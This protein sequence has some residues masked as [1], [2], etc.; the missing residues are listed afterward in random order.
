MRTL[1]SAKNL[2][3]SLGITFIVIFLGFV[4]R[5]V[6]VDNIG[7]QYLGLNG[8][9]TNILGMMALLEGGF[10]TSV[11]YNMYKPLAEDDRPRIIALL[12][13]YRKVYRYIAL[14]LFLFSLALYPFLG[15]FLKDGDGLEYV[16][17]VYFIFVFNS[18]V[19]YFTAYKWSIINASQQVYK[20]TGYNLAYQIAQNLTKLA[21]LYYTKNYI[22]YLLV[23]SALLLLLN[24][25]IVH[26]ANQLFPYIRTKQKHI[27]DKDTKREIV[28][29]MKNLF[30]NKVG[31]YFMFS[32]D[33][34]IISSFVSVATVGLY[35]NYTLL[36]S[37]VKSLVS[38]SLDSFSESV[39]NLIASENSDKVYEIFK[40][41]FFFNFLASS[42]A[43]I[44]LY[45]TLTPFIDW[46][47]GSQYLLT[48]A[49][50]VVILL[51]FYVDTMRTSALTFKIKA[52][53]FKQDRWTPFLQ[54]V[55]NLVLSL[56]FV[57]YW[58][59]TGVLFATLIAILSIGFWQFPR[60]CYK[61][62]FH[63]SLWLY[64]QRYAVYTL[65]ACAALA[66]SLGIIHFCKVENLF[67]QCVINGSISLA[68]SSVIYVAA[69]HCTAEY[70]VLLE[71]VRAILP[72]KRHN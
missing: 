70:R 54:G 3:S 55:I 30:I 32:T 40:S 38:K 42:L 58:G 22:L 66:A 24:V 60:L 19:G 28:N 26:K 33:N 4:T 71:H 53:L 43:V 46:W 5:K 14:G 36:T 48:H 29:N 6:F 51:N 25:G 72:K 49:T 15:Y 8:L 35:S 45:C 41:A 23:E 52:G 2:A 64:F 31:G 10:S 62:I 37:T 27:V 11:V 1:N 44:I 50:V 39:G 18:I 57:Q 12:Q 7:V 13:L 20:L 67:L 61:Y 69:F 56:I 9:L 68:L 34:I 59:L 16:S 65:T 63:R 17:V 47:L 21:I